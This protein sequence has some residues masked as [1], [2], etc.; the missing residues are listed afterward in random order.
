MNTWQF[1]LL[2]WQGVGPMCAIFLSFVY[3]GLLV[4]AFP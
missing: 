3:T 4:Q 1:N 2:N